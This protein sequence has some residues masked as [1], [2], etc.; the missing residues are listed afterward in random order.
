MKSVNCLES[1]RSTR[2]RVA[3]SLVELV[4][5]IGIIALLIG[6]LI[7]TIS[8]A[9]DASRRVNCMSNLRQLTIAWT[10]FATH[11][12]GNLVGSNNSAPTDWVIGGNTRSEIQNGLLFQY[13]P[14]ITVY[15]CPADYSDH[16]RSYSLNAYFNGEVTVYRPAP[17]LRRIGEQR[18]IFPFPLGSQ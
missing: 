11:H 6:I 3:F 18:Y 17:V 10:E 2:R 8:K 13:C 14:I 15:H 9:R 4:V 12:D 5:V 7:P 16:Y 1:R